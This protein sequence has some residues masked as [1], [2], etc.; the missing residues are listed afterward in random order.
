MQTDIRTIN[1]SQ[2]LTRAEMVRALS[3]YADARAEGRSDFAQRLADE[4][5]EP[6]LPG[7]CQA[8][9]QTRDALDLAHA[10]EAALNEAMMTIMSAGESENVM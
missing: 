4:V 8:L 1:P 5:I 6:V 10:I 9:G 2:F 3:L 7:I